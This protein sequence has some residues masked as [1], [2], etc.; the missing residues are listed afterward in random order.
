[1]RTLS[2]TLKAAQQAGAI[3]GLVKL[4]LTKGENSYTYTKILDIE[5][6]GDGPLQS[7]KLVLK[8]SDKVLTDLD[9]RGFQG[10]LSYGAVTSADE[11]YSACAPMWVLA[12]KFDSDPNK[13]ECT[14]SLVGI[15]NLMATDEASETYQPDQDDTKSVKTLVNAIAGATLAPFTLC[16]AYTVEWDEGYDTLADT[17]IPKDA[18]RIYP[19]NNRLS[20]INRLLDYTKN[21]MLAKA[22]GKLHIFK[23]TTSGESYDY[24]YSLESGHPFFAKALRNRIV[25]P[26]YIKVQSQDDDDPQYS[27]TAKDDGYDS[28]PAELKKQQYK[29]T[30]LESDAQATAIAEA[31]LAKAQMWCEAG[32]ADV[33]LNVG[34]EAFDYVKVTDKREGDYRVGNIGRFTRNYNLTK[35]EWTMNFVFGNWQNVRK[36]LDQL[37]ITADDIENYF[38]RLKVGD[39][40]VEHILAENIDLVWIDP[41][42]TIDLSKI[43]DTLDNLPD[44]EVFARVKSIHISAEGGIKLDEHILYSPGYDPSTKWT[45]S[46]LDDLP[47]GATYQRVRSSA[48]TTGGLII[49]DNVISGTY[50]L[51]K[52]TD[53]TAGHIRLSRCVGDLDDIDDGGTYEK[54][55]ATDIDSGHIKLSSYTVVEGEWYN[56]GGVELDANYGI[57]IYGQNNALTTRATKTGTIQCYVGSDGCIYAGSGNV[58]LSSTGIDLI[59]KAMRLNYGGTLKGGIEANSYGVLFGAETGQK[60]TIGIGAMGILSGI[61]IAAP[62]LPIRFLGTRVDMANVERMVAPRKSSHPSSPALGTMYRNTS[63]GEIYIYTNAGSGTRW[64]R[65]S[66]VAA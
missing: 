53:I 60:L 45:G 2:D 56:E 35:N 39:L 52:S 36:A 55:R 57:N 19:G 66:L 42:G 23:P 33:P 18:F 3:N 26:G 6:K 10:V 28:L 63:D 59:G 16:K 22:D 47:D 64:Y 27:G 65:C 37:G 9:L 24:E 1:M 51:V 20:A 34:Q 29:K 12:Q 15:C 44:G 50:G 54:L 38:S 17:Y 4:E 25:T 21:V 30:Y 58:K 8:N 61:T 7:L 49:L 48:L 46:D 32:A 41:D 5:E 40:Y 14:L 11:E 43:G 13:L 31:I 62:D